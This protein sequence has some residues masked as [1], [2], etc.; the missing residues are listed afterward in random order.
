MFY[1]INTND[2]GFISA[3]FSFPEGGSRIMKKSIRLTAMVF[4]AALALAGCSSNNKDTSSDASDASQT[5]AAESAVTPPASLPEFSDHGIEYQMLVTTKSAAKEELLKGSWMYP[6]NV[7]FGK[8][9]EKDVMPDA[10]KDAWYYGSSIWFNDDG[11]GILTIGGY[12]STISYT[13][14]N[15]CTISIVR[16]NPQ[17]NELYAIGQHEEFG[18]ILYSKEDPNVIFYQAVF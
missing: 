16:G 14:N 9:D 2:P 5:S 18:T 12:D 15:D 1:R 13:I 10:D 4:A 7:A 6:T 8:D 17:V 11:T 3:V